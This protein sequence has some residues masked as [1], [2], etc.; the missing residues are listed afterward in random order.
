MQVN[1]RRIS[2]VEEVMQ[3]RTICLTKSVHVFKVVFQ[4]LC[5]SVMTVFIHALFE[6]A[7]KNKENKYKIKYTLQGKKVSDISAS[8]LTLFLDSRHIK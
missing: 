8:L 1:E 7:H 6:Y 4:L 3:Q 2:Y 5:L